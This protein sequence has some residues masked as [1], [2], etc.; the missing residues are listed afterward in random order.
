MSIHVLGTSLGLGADIYSAHSTCCANDE[1]VGHSE[2][3]ILEF[4]F[5]SVYVRERSISP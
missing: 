3:Y 4:I 5:V 2:A 1:E